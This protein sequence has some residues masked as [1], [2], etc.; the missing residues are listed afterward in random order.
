MRDALV[1]RDVA[2]EEAKKPT[3]TEEEVGGYVWA[4]G[5]DGRPL[6]EE[7]LKMDDHGCDAMRYAVAEIDLAARPRVRIMG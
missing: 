4:P 6:K 2:L 1:E 3:C 7:P 5:V